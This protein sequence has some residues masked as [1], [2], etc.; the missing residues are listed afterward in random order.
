M[1]SGVNMDLQPRQIEVLDD[2]MAEVL[3]AQSGSDRLKTASKLYVLAHR[4]IA[5][6]LTADHPDWSHRQVEDEAARRLSHGA[7]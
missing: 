3:R 5:A 1:P 7:V 2:Q 6:K 4:L